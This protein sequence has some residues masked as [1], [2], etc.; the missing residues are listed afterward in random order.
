MSGVSLEWALWGKPLELTRSLAVWGAFLMCCSAMPSSLHDLICTCPW[1]FEHF[2]WLTPCQISFR[3]Q[4]NIHKHN[5]HVPLM[6]SML[7]SFSDECY[8]FYIWFSS[9]LLITEALV[10]FYLLKKSFSTPL[11]KATSCLVLCS[12]LSYLSVSSFSNKSST[13]KLSHLFTQL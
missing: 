8:S 13:F 12:I 11:F 1:S 2:L 7:F 9:R 4:F 3:D 6:A 5:K 10:K